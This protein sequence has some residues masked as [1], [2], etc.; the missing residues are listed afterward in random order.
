MN[1]KLFIPQSVLDKWVESGKVTFNDNILTLLKEQRSYTLTSAVRFMSMIDG[2]DTHQLIGKIRTLQ[3]LEELGGEHMSDSVILGDTAYTVQEGFIGVVLADAE[4]ASEA[5]AIPQGMAAAPFLA[6]AV[7]Q[8]VA[9]APVARSVTV[10]TPVAPTLPSASIEPVT[11]A[12]PDLVEAPLPPPVDIHAVELTAVPL[13]AAAPA[14]A[15]A[16]TAASLAQAAGDQP[17][18][19]SSDA[20][21]LTKFLLNNL[22]F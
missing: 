7:A 21:M 6:P 3:K 15:A 18:D 22:N 14:P 13:A 9:A 2:V 17:K 8:P 5:E 10:P 11:T 16:S 1:D 12:A 20:D 4:V 19:T